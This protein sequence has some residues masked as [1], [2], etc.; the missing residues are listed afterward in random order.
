[1]NI[2]INVKLVQIYSFYH[3]ID[4]FYFVDTIFIAALPY[5]L[6]TTFQY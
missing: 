4:W 3:L 5:I 2:H 6:H 1:M